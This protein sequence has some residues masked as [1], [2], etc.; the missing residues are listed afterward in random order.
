M[1]EPRSEILISPLASDPLTRTFQSSPGVS[2]PRPFHAF[3]SPY[4]PEV[5]GDKDY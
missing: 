2:H 1:L 3:P 4:V 5:I